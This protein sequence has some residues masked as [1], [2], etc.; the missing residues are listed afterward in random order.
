MVD[1]W[2]SGEITCPGFFRDWIID[3]CGYWIFVDIKIWWKS[4]R[5]VDPEERSGSG[6]G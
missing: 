1:I 5:S 3:I 2:P 4:E 6:Y